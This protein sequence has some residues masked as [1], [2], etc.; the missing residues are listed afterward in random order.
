M[1]YAGL[2]DWQH[3]TRL[4]CQGCHLLEGKEYCW[5]E[6]REWW[7]EIRHGTDQLVSCDTRVTWSFR[8]F[9]TPFFF[10]SSFCCS[11]RNGSNGFLLFP[12]KML[13]F[14]S[15]L[16][17]CL[18]RRI[19][20][21]RLIFF[22]FSFCF[23]LPSASSLVHLPFFHSA[24]F[25]WLLV[26]HRTIIAAHFQNETEPHILLATHRP[27]CCIRLYIAKVFYIAPSP[28]QSLFLEPVH[29][30]FNPIVKTEKSIKSLRSPSPTV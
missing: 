24:N 12:D 3:T 23:R 28:L 26:A 22:I 30:S 21:F 14:R 8:Y 5:N 13:R 15:A 16:F 10:L 6:C 25:Q 18:C 19:I 1:L 29:R 17:H 4:I 7:I 9:I 2:G 27:L 20:P 11:S